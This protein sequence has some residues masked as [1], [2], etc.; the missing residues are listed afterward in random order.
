MYIF[1]PP[2][3]SKDTIIYFIT[4]TFPEESTPEIKQKLNTICQ[5]VFCGQI[6]GSAKVTIL[7]EISEKMVFPY[8]I[9][10]FANNTA[11]FY[12]D[13]PEVSSNQLFF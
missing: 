10:I 13:T 6:S 4:N 11:K 8:V 12:E 2:L 1:H 5:E 9:D 7:N 3:F